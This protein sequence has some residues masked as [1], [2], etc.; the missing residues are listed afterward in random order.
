MDAFTENVKTR[1][2]LVPITTTK[3]H[4]LVDGQ[5]RIEAYK[6][7]GYEYIPVYEI[8][9][10]IKEDGEIDA[11]LVRDSFTVTELLAI[12]KYRESMEPNLQG[13]R[14]DK[15]LGGNISPK[16]S[17]A[18]EQRIAKDTKLSYK[19]L[20]HLEEV[21][22]AAKEVPEKFGDFP[23]KIDKGMKINKAWTILRNHKKRE[24]QITEAAKT[25]LS[26]IIHTR[27]KQEIEESNRQAAEQLFVLRRDRAL[28]ECKN[29][30]KKYPKRKH[31]IIQFLIEALQELDV[32]S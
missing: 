15:E 5:R 29:A 20:N 8:D 16:L 25:S 27:T 22:Q 26:D 31:E 24:E 13:K 14:N 17:H 18:R 4:L 23:A 11:N 32:N 1:G 3:G 28:D 10:P 19:T 7:L 6:R 30:I 21:V 2:L 9:I 12:K